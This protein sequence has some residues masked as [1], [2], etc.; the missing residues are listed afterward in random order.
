MRYHTKKSKGPQP[1][2]LTI[3][4]ACDHPVYSWCTL[5]QFSNDGRGLAII[6]QKFN[7]DGKY[8]WWDKVDDWIAPKIYLSPRFKDYYERKAG[9]PVNGLYPTVT[10]RQAM[11]ALRLKPLPKQPWET[12]FDRPEI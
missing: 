10:V 5:F 6:Q 1:I 2:N 4:Y 7:K 3:P 11:W 8:T 12:V 9:K